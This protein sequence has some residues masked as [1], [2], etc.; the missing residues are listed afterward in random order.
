MNERSLPDKILNY[1]EETGEFWLRFVLID[2]TS[3]PARKENIV[4]TVGCS[5]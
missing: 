2:E 5:R 1:F 3:L 4:K